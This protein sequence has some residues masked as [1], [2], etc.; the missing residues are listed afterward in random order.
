MVSY[1]P[2]EIII[3]I[4]QRGNLTID[5]KYSMRDLLRIRN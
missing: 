1:S 3:E 5:E 2:V 4:Q